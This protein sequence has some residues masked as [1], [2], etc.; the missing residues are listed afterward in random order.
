MGNDTCNSLFD[1]VLTSAGP[2]TTE[3]I[4]IM[5]SQ[6]GIDFAA[7]SHPDL[8]YRI[9]RRPSY[10]I[11]RGV[12]SERAEVVKAALNEIGAAAEIQPSRERGTAGGLSPDRLDW[13]EFP[14]CPECGVEYELQAL[15]P[16]ATATHVECIACGTQVPVRTPH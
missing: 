3:V 13:I 15:R 2:N 5:Q 1:V 12:S 9:L 14:E 11:I 6:T 8:A 7:A 16:P 4:A 10:R